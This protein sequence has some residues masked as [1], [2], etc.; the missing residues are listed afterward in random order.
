MDTRR[1]DSAA[2][3]RRFL[4]G[5]TV[6]VGAAAVGRWATAEARILSAHEVR[7]WDEVADVVVIG[8]GAAGANAAIAAHD[9]G[10]KV[11]LLEKMSAGGGNSGVCFGGMVI[12]NDVAAA[13]DYYR[14][15]SFGTV[16]E[17]MLRGFAEAMC[18]VYDLVRGYGGGIKDRAWGSTF[19]ALKNVRLSVFRFNPTGKDGMEFLS[20]LVQQRGITVLLETPA[21]CL[22]QV[23]ETGEVVGVQAEHQGRMIFIKAGRGIVLSCG[24]YENNPEMF[25][26]Y[27]YPGLRDFIFPLGNPGNTGDGVKMASAAGAYLWHTTALQWGGLCAKR[28]SQ[29]YGVAIGAIN[30]RGA[31]TLSYV[32]VNKYG[33]RFMRETKRI[34]HSKEPLDVLHFD[35]EQAEYPNMPAY[36]ILDESAFGPGGP[37]LRGGWPHMGYARIHKIY[38]WMNDQAAEFEKGWISKADT[39]T[40][41]ARKIMVDPKGLEDTVG[42]FNQYC[43][44]GTDLQF[45]RGKEAMAPI[46]K[47]PYYAVEMGLAL[48]NTQ[49]GPKHDRYARV[50]DPDDKPIPRLYAAGELGSFF[51]FLYQEGSNYPEAWVFGRIAGKGAAAE[52]PFE[53]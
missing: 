4:R 44:T 39:L 16:D 49:G 23:P 42:R 3:R 43:R 6:G 50:L 22:V 47:A 40:E 17:D 15:L 48:V 41:L 31:R 12:P 27:N 9:A 18:G 36:L 34:A 35:H 45:G 51:G 10:A 11:L 29:R 46:E 21:K 28:P 1:D 53:G 24:G 25:G 7:K 37:L 14:T 19:P 5:L 38:D 8:Y 13:V 32:F 30:A 20:R 26:Y 52:K 2:A 33:N